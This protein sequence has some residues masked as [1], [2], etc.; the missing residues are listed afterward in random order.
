M[1]SRSLPLR[2]SD[3][4][5]FRTILVLGLAASVFGGCT[6]S[7][8]SSR[9]PAPGPASIDLGPLRTTTSE[10]VA[11]MNLD[12]SIRAGRRALERRL[13]VA[14]ASSLI[15]ALMLRADLYGTFD[16]WDEALAVSETVL[17]ADAHDPDALLL[18]ARVLGTLHEFDESLALIERAR[19]EI[20]S[21]GSSRAAELEA[22]ARNLEAN[23]RLALESPAD[24][25]V[26]ERRVLASSSPSFQ[27]S[28][29]LALA[30]AEQGAFDEADE[31]FLRALRGYRD[32][33][34]FPFAWVA[35][36]RGV[37]WSEMAGRPDLGR[38]LYE[39]ALVHLPGYVLA[40]VHLAELD[41]LDG[42]VEA[43]VE[44]LQRLLGTTQDP[45]PLAVLADIVPSSDDARRYATEAND[46]YQRLT[47]RF[48]AAFAHH[49]P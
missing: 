46:A 45:E 24:D 25:V 42:E 28:T 12:A 49:A 36:Q 32:V 18:R 20:P 2:T 9:G 3:V 38:A 11:V 34:P 21:H 23:A 10:S 29:G 17:E 35:F 5:A 39:R 7:H 6:P 13:D 4:R 30:L 48:P 44:R 8:D 14:R 16:D 15:D 43:A 26:A 33:S 19:A 1:D 40:N 27:H 47:R 41:A 31:A 37:M 22:S